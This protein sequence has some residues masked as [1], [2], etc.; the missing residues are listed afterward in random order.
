MGWGQAKGQNTPPKEHMKSGGG[1]MGHGPTK[2]LPPIAC[3]NA[4]T[5]KAIYNL[6]VY[7]I[8]YAFLKL[9]NKTYFK[10][11][12]SSK[13]SPPQVFASTSTCIFFRLL[14]GPAHALLVMAKK[15]L[16]ILELR[17]QT[18]ICR[19]QKTKVIIFYSK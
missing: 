8:L 19:V 7:F 9:V 15:V 10:L 17:K 18:I 3:N 5:G 1:A 6:F 4:D 14:M 12:I 13:P 16:T 11:I 2:D